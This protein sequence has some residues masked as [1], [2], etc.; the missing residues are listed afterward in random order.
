MNIDDEVHRHQQDGIK[1]L[2]LI[3]NVES[4]NHVLKLLSPGSLQDTYHLEEL[5]TIALNG[6]NLLERNGCHQVR[7][8]ASFNVVPGYHPPGGDFITIVIIVSRPDAYEDVHNID[9]VDNH[10]NIPEDRK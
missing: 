9:P 6:E 4:V 1:G 3:L 8:D 2:L 7:N 5:L 10:I